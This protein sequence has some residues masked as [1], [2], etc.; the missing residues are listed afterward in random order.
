MRNG[1]MTAHQNHSQLIVTQLLF[2]FSIVGGERFGVSEMLGCQRSRFVRSQ[3]A[4]ANR[5]Q[6]RIA[7][8][9]KQPACGI[10]GDASVRPVLQCFE[11]CVLR[12]FFGQLDMLRTEQA[13]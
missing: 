13:G 12:D 11:Q 10:L 3:S 4:M 2:E 9:A 5:V 6:R 1:G 7:G 8:H